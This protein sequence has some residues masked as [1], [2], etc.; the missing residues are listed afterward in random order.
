M[1]I[2]NTKGVCKTLGQTPSACS[3]HKNQQK[4]IHIMS[5]NEWWLRFVKR[6]RYK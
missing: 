6:L 4:F 3:S 2:Q 1:C 5:G